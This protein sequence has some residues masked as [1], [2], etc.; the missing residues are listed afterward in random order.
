MCL[1]QNGTAIDYIRTEIGTNSNIT[2]QIG[3]VGKENTASKVR[4]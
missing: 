3:A 1:Q 2:A 4:N